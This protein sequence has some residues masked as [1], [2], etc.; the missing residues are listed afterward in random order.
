M[1]YGHR[2][3]LVLVSLTKRCLQAE[4][5]A[6]MRLQFLQ[7][8]DKM[9]DQWITPGVIAIIEPMDEKGLELSKEAEKLGYDGRP[10]ALD[11]YAEKF[12]VFAA[13]NPSLQRAYDA[14]FAKYEKRV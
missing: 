2:Y 6:E 7:H 14:A 11:V 4:M 8:L 3:T 9:T 12:D 13:L 5:P 10:S 1:S